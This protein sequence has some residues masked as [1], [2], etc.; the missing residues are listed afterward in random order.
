MAT[1]I[2]ATTIVTVTTYTPLA[3][4]NF[5]PLIFSLWA[6][7]P[8]IHGGLSYSTD[9]VGVVLA[10]SGFGLFVS[11]VTLYPLVERFLGPVMIC[12]IAGV[13]SIP[14]LASYPLIAMLSGSTLSVVLNCAS[15]LKNVLSVSIITGM[16]LLQNSAVDQHQR[17]T[18]N[19][20]SMTAM[21]LFKAAGPAGG[22]ALFSW[23]QKRQDSAFF[24]DGFL[25]PECGR[26]NRTA[27]DIQTISSSKAS[28]EEN[29]SDS[30]PG[31]QDYHLDQYDSLVALHL[32]PFIMG[33]I[34]CIL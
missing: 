18:A 27:H 30:T 22:G 20:I 15:V 31:R 7:S 13:L 6:V 25:N 5:L 8:R 4:N 19:G 3:T 11:Q 16:F 26:G 14:L 28:I 21:S 29:Q 17:G 9:D 10:I 34:T 32:S 23:A 24:P 33:T 1:I 2:S 12:R